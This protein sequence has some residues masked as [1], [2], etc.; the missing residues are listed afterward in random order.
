MEVDRVDTCKDMVLH[1]LGYAILPSLI[2][3]RV[4][5]VNTLIIKD[6]QGQPIIRKTSLIYQKE[7]TDINL[8]RAFV[9]YTCEVDFLVI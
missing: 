4:D 5:N 8:V 9:E 6:R 3:D 7:L 2:L 1:G